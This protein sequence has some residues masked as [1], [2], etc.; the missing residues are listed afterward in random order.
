M[1]DKRTILRIIVLGVIVIAL[2]SAFYSAYSSDKSLAAVGNAAPDFTLT[3]LEGA[4]VSLSDFRG[5]GV[6][7]NFWATWCGPC[8]R[9]MPLMEKHYQEVKD[10]GIEILAVNIAESNVAVSSF[11]ERIGVTFPVLLDSN[12]DR[13]VTQRYGVGAL[14]ASYFVD[15]DGVIVG[16]YVGEM[17]ESILKEH[18]EL[19]KP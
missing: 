11:I 16:H 13:V 8:K 10:E 15:K 2:G 14:P 7:I 9:E 12:P 6:F 19:I 1:K 17:N 4:E 18:L 3:N 5:K